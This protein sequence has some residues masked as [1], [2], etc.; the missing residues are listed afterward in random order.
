MINGQT[1]GHKRKMSVASTKRFVN[2]ATANP[3]RCGDNINCYNWKC[4]NDNS[5]GRCNIGPQFSFAENALLRQQSNFLRALFLY[6]V[7]DF[8]EIF[9]DPS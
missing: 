8:I 2:I 6:V 5:Y 1:F 9:A 3:N 4:C 7:N